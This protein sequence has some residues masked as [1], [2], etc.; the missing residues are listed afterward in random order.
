MHNAEEE[1]EEREPQEPTRK[2]EVLSTQ[3]RLNAQAWAARL[4]ALLEARSH[5]PE[6]DS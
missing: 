2:T 3:L 4:A 5:F 6:N 1:E